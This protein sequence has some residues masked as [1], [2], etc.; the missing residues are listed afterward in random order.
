MSEKLTNEKRNRDI[1]D[2]ARH[3]NAL[4]IADR[5]QL[6]RTSVRR[7]A[8]ALGVYVLALVGLAVFVPQYAPQPSSPIPV[9][10]PWVVLAAFVFETMDSASGMGCGATL[11]ALLLAFGYRPLAVVPVL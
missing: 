6:D 5:I 2:V 10:V 1:G 8:L 7:I 3:L 11:G 9:F 4:P